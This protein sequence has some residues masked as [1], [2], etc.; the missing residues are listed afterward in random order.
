MGAAQVETPLSRT[1]DSVTVIDRAEL[2]ATQTTSVADALRLVPGFSIAASGGP[3]ALTSIFPRGGKSD[4]TLVLV[5]GIP[6]NAFGGGFDAGHLDT[7]GVERVEVVRGPE[8]A[9][10][11]DGAIG[12]IVHLVTR[13][14]G[15][16]QA[17]AAIDGIY[18]L[19]PTQV[20]ISV[21]AA[22]EANGSGEYWANFH[23][24]RAG[25]A[26]FFSE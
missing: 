2:T 11:G 19:G 25:D 8:S 26:A 21:R 22:Q 14:G 24:D 13:Q 5:D 16:L 23:G 20:D 12:G 17:D 3:G 4:Y 9:L 6:Q 1:S 7:A 18:A 10:Y 15:P